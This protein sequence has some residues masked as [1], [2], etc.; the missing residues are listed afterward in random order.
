MFIYTDKFIA[1]C[2]KKSGNT[3]LF[4]NIVIFLRTVKSKVHYFVM[5]RYLSQERAEIFNCT[6]FKT[7]LNF[8]QNLMMSDDANVC[9]SGLVN[10][11]TAD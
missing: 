5:E 9:F 4:L 8:C 1:Y 2:Y 10:T 3:T 11:F 6:Y 7:E